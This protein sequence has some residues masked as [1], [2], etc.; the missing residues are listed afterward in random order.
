M[1]SLLLVGLLVGVASADARRE[2]KVFEDKAVTAT[3][4][5]CF[6]T[7]RWDQ[8]YVYGTRVCLIRA[9][10]DVCSGVVFELDGPARFDPQILDRVSC[11][12]NGNTVTFKGTWVAC[13]MA[14]R[15]TSTPLSFNGVLA[16]DRLRGAYTQGD[17]K[18]KVSWKRTRKTFDT[19]ALVRKECKRKRPE[20]SAVPDAP[21]PDL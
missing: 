4:L 15:C 5:G 14:S 16:G 11:G 10:T 20:P 9:A 8:D 1:R 17:D 2:C 12:G 13:D 19:R 3:D 6:E 21:F 7:L 18:T